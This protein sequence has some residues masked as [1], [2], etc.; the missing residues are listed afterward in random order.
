MPK[1][2]SSK[3]FQLVKSMT[4]SEKRYFKVFVG[5]NGGKSSKYLRL[6]DAIEAQ[7]NFDDEAL[8]NAVYQGEPVQSRKYSELKAYLYDLLLKSLQSYD[9]KTSVDYKLR[10]LMQSIRVLFR[11]SLF[12][13]CLDLLAKAR[14]V[15]DKYE[16]FITLLD[17]LWWE[18]QIAYA[19]T[20]IDFL[21]EELQRID[22]EEKQ[23]L[24]RVR[25]ISKYRNLFFQLLVSLRKDA[26]L[27]GPEHQRRVADIISSP[28]LQSQAEADSHQAQIYYYRTL[29]IYQLATGDV[30]GFN[31]NSEK[32]I[33]LMES[34]PHFLREDVSE[35][36]SALS[37][38]IMSCGRLGDYDAL[39]RYLEKLKNVHPLSKDD[40]VK[41]HRQ[42]YQNKFSLCIAK[43]DFAEGQKALAEHLRERARF[44]TDL[45]ETNTFY[46]YYFHISFGAGA[47]DN[48]L[49]Y[50]NA[51]LNL[52]S[53]VERQELQGIARILNLIVHFELGNYVLLDSLLRSTYRYLKKRQQLHG[54]EREIISFIRK[55]AGSPSKHELRTAYEKLKTEFEEL[56]KKEQVKSFFIRAF[57]VIAWL[58]S[59]LEDKPYGEILQRKFRERP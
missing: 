11:R 49:S 17:I 10:H 6:F 37:N 13:D 48:A 33:R 43:G 59:K 54:V 14:K 50:L 51:W 3:L 52:N 44:D 55:A 7:E 20:D 35:Y 8:K 19:R 30:K 15:A 58:E 34:K 21:D 29:S 27:S 53:T 31:Q 22:Q 23:L 42:Y 32:L 47:Y 40:E 39:E 5:S 18:K 46:Y 38:L 45:F 25:N 36:I 16:Q 26:S 57:D 56:P 9:E 1:T 41:I 4:G 2:P 24:Q 12:T 28:L